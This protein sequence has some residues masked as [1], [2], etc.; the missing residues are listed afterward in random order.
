MKKSDENRYPHS[1]DLFKFCKE[2]LNIKHNFEV[3]VIDQHVGAI[4]GYDPADCSHW[5][6]GKKNIKSLQTINTIATHL[7]VDPRFVTDI[8]SGKM[9]L[10]ESIQE[11]KGY[12][13]FHVSTRYYD[14]LKREYFRNPSK[15]AH[16]GETRSFEQVVDLQR[17]VARTLTNEILAEANIGSCPIMIPEF[18][19]ALPKVVLQESATSE[20]LVHSTLDNGTVTITFRS[21]EMRPHLRYLIAREVGRAYLYPQLDVA[22]SDELACARLN[23][24]ASLLLIPGDLLQ[25]AT[26]QIDHTRDLVEQ[27]AEI[28]WVSRAIMNARLMDFF[29]HGN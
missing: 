8:I 20:K 5:K 9:N 12:G 6:K 17:G 3:K 29:T 11:Y 26:R 21:G 18:S 27:L 24:F 14:E 19:G 22:E 23:L 2:A 16:N 1:A 15:F 7:D 13:P 28:F 10:E 4:L 25:K